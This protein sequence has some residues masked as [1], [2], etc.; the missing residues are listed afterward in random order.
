MGRGSDGRRKKVKVVWQPG[1]VAQLRVAAIL[2]ESLR[3]EVE[4][5]EP[6]AG[7]RGRQLQQTRRQTSVRVTVEKTS[8]TERTV[9]HSGAPVL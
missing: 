9:S 5:A 2:L 8:S 1:G 7:H 6:G 4:D 3:R